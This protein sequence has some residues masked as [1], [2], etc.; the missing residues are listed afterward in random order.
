MVGHFCAVQL[1]SASTQLGIKAGILN[2]RTDISGELPG[3]ELK[4]IMEFSGGAFLKLNFDSG[5]LGIQPEILYATK[6]FDARETHDG[7][8][9]SSKYKI[10]YFEIPIL[11]SYRLFS[12]KKIESLLLLGP[13]FGFPGKVREIQTAGE[14][15]EVRELGDNLKKMDFG[16]VIGF[17]IRYRLKSLYFILAARYN[18]GLS[19]ISRDIQ[20][21][22]YDLDEDDTIKNKSFSLMFGLAFKI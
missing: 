17:D 18:R 4:S 22:S 6:G 19:N 3:I 11:V 13:Y 15:T 1:F 21:V 20:E 5:R 7:L 14:Q 8:E 9:I 10:T 12:G 2:V 16:V